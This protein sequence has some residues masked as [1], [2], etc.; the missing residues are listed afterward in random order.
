MSKETHELL[1]NLIEEILKELKDE[2]NNEHV[3]ITFYL[4]KKATKEFEK[5]LD[6]INSIR[7]RHIEELAYHG[8]YR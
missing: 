4:N 8:Y 1:K 3:M 2:A 5:A 7:D 6:A